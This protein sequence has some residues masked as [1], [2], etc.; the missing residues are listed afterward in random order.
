MSNS[1]SNQI[2]RLRLKPALM[3]VAAVCLLM[4]L[5]GG[6]AR[7][8]WMLPVLHTNLVSQHGALMLSGF[9]GA[10]IA[11]ERAVALERRWAYAAPALAGL[12]GLALSIGLPDWIGRSL[13]V[14]G[15]L[16][17]IAIFIFIVKHKPD[18]AHAMMGAGA[19][20]WCIGNGLWWLDG[21]IYHSVP[22]W[23]GFLLLTIVGERVEL[24]R[25]LR[26]SHTLYLLLFSLVGVYV[27]GLLIGLAQFQMGISVCGA[28]LLGVSVWMLR[29][30][31]A[32][33]TIHKS[34]LTRFIAACLLLGQVWLGVAGALWLLL[35]QQFTA[36]FGYDAMLHIVL[37]G[38]VFSMIFGH[39]PVIVPGVL[40]LPF[41]YSPWLYA[42]LALLHVSLLVRL[43]SDALHDAILRMWGG[44]F[45][46]IAVLS[47]LALAVWSVLRVRKQS[48]SNAPAH[49]PLSPIS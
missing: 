38:F 18:A 30:D 12:G 32:R 13:I 29:F 47:F 31:I 49:S 37:I 20:L 25:V 48:Q 6:L 27:I 14:A 40:R 21:P 19:L 45:N 15:S 42:P 7:L 34:G 16:G 9:L 10:L 1:I 8:G 5:W 23:V 44:L 39:A 46:E 17:L 3:A 2:A 41:V 33:R 22:W 35:A 43:L 28:A 36:G 4:G 26:L 11:L 24:S